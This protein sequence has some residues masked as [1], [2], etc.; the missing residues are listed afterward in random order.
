MNKENDILVSIS[1]I[2]YNHVNYIKDALDGFLSQKT[3]FS[4]EI[5]IHD[6]ASTDGTEEIIREY[7]SK[8]PELIKPLYEEENQWKKGIRGSA[9]FNFPRAKGKYIALCEGDDY[10]TDPLKLQKQVDFLKKH[11]NINLT[12]HFAKAV[13]TIKNEEYIIGK[14]SKVLFTHEDIAHK[15][16]RIPTSSL[17]FRNNIIW[18]DWIFRVYAGDRAII[19]LNSLKGDLKILEFT[20]SIYRI[21]EGGVEQ[22]FKNDKF[23]LPKRNIKEDFIYF[24]LNKRPYVKW[25]LYKKILWNQ[26]YYFYWSCRKG[27]LKKCFKSFVS[28]LKF[29]VFRKI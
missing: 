11:Q 29:A 12:G 7:A 18:P 16:L 13:D 27:D 8:Y 5:L 14:H 20:G 6:D 2:T 25:K 9:V 28:I 26:S 19:Y 17:V 24:K 22:N 10:W 1:T 15:N 3:N 4:Y 21:H 23:K